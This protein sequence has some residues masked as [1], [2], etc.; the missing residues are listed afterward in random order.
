MVTCLITSV[1]P[2]QGLNVSFLGCSK[3]TIPVDHLQCHSTTCLE[4]NG[5]LKVGQ[6]ICARILWDTI[7]RSQEP[8]LN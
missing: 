1:I 5:K 8:H 6:K 4:L 3:I 2:G 7:S